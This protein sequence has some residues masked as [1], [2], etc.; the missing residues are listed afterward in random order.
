MFT[1][2]K[3]ILAIIDQLKA[4]F[5]K[6]TPRVLERSKNNPLL[7]IKRCRVAYVGCPQVRAFRAWAVTQPLDVIE[8]TI[9]IGASKHELAML[10][11]AIQR[12][13]I[14]PNYFNI[15]SAAVGH[16]GVPKLPTNFV[17]GRL[18]FFGALHTKGGQLRLADFL[19]QWVNNMALDVEVYHFF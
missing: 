16:E 13:G 4:G 19:E 3:D 10:D 5:V 11:N 8:K 14:P 18:V 2:A 1:D 6:L 7:A 15:A 17:I 12:T 9:L